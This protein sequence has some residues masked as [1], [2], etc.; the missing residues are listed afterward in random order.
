MVIG[1]LA[2]QRPAKLQAT[3]NKSHYPTLLLAPTL[4]LVVADDPN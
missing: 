3:R 2:P 4:E 1:T